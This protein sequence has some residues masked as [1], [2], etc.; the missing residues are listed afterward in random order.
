MGG[1]PKR[2][3]L[4]EIFLKVSKNQVLMRTSLHTSRGMV[5]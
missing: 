1:R 3:Y 2:I 4:M 5:L